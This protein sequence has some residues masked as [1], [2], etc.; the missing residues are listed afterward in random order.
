MSTRTHGAGSTRSAYFHTVDRETFSDR[1]S[2]NHPVRR[3]RP[4]LHP[5]TAS[6]QASFRLRPM[7]SFMISVV[8]P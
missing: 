4:R 5:E 3:A 6:Y 8:P 1:P 7:I 2:T